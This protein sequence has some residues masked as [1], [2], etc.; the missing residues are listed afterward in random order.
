MSTIEF[1]SHEQQDEYIYNIFNKKQNGFFLDI[2]CGNPTIGSNSY[3]LEKFCGWTGIG[4]D[5][6]DV[7]ARDGWSSKRTSPFVQMDVTSSQM[8]EYLKTNI[9]ADLVVDYISLDVDAG[10][11]SLALQAL[12]RVLD[13]GVKFKAMTFEHEYHSHGPELRDTQRKLLEAQGMVML[14]EDVKGWTI[15]N[16]RHNNTEYYEDW[17]IHPDYFDVSLLG[18]KTQGLYTFECVEVLRN[19][20]NQNDYTADHVCCRSFPDEYKLFWDSREE[21]NWPYLKYQISQLFEQY[22]SAKR[23]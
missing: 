8:T 12:Q 11:T 18:V 14:F 19:Y 20:L 1:H 2:S 9:P 10:G 6:L 22:N 23:A 13:A 16:S 15:G 4:F 17:W 21:A 7:E 3:T 5:I